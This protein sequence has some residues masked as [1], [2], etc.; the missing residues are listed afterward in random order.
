M[1]KQLLVI[2]LGQVGFLLWG[3][4]T[5]LSSRINTLLEQSESL[6][7]TNLDSALHYANAAL[8]EATNSGDTKHIFDA[9]RTIGYVFEEN[10]Q[11]QEALQAYQ[12]ALELAENKLTDIEKY[13]I[14][15]DWAILNKKMGHYAIAHDYH[16]Q[17]IKI[18]E[19]IANWEVAESGYNGLG[20]MYT[21]MG[22]PEKAIHYYQKSIEAADKSGNKVGIILTKE[23]IVGI[24]LKS[25]NYTVALQK[26]KEVFDMAT[27]LSDSIRIAAVLS[28]YGDV[29]MAMGQS[30]KALL[31][32]QKANQLLL[33]SGDKTLLSKSYLSLGSYYFE[34]NKYEEAHYNFNQ[35]KNLEAYMYPVCGAELYQKL[36]KL[37]NSQGEN[38]KAIE[39]F[40]KSLE[41]TDSLGLKDIARDNHLALGNIFKLEQQYEIAY[42]HIALANQLGDDIFADT[43]AK[44]ANAEQFKIDIEKRDNQI[45]AQQTELNQAETIRVIL[46]ISLVVVLGILFFTWRQM[47]AKLNAMQHIELLM[48]ELHHRVKNNLQTVTSI[49]RLQ[50]RHITDPSVLQ[51]LGESRS[52][53]EAI[54]MIH[55]QLYR[56]DDVQS[57]N[58][59]LFLEGLVEKQQFTYGMSDTKL[60]TII[61]LENE[62]INVD[63]ALPLGLIINELLTNSFKYAYPSVSKPKLQIDI[64][65]E[66]LF[67]A[68][69]GGGLPTQ[70]T[71]QDSKSFGIQLITSLAQQL[72]GKFSFGNDNGMFFKLVFA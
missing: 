61:T 64:S 65:H 67:Y 41:K 10:S 16:W 51:V 15:N 37:Y 8:Y 30:D 27:T 33:H 32:Y 69:N 20:T 11:L 9:H 35:C 47:K 31:K 6:I 23:N 53:L 28:L 62:Y 1:K 14:Y 40:K 60:E 7:Y 24:Y 63:L 36:G 13:K 48:K 68:D 44:N 58:F 38:N 18:G 42:Q 22:N 25:R 52:R 26:V 66:K 56:S 34:K 5:I 57:V 19:K 59:K 17:T 50:A 4:N 46:G 54:S 29:E 21:M 3:Q 70:F 39:A 12:K 49:M 71:N 43:K 55:Q 72:R 2:L 45:A